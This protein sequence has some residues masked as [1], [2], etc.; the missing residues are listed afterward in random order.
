MAVINIDLANP[1]WMGKKLTIDDEELLKSLDELDDMIEKPEA[2]DEDKTGSKKLV[3]ENIEYFDEDTKSIQKFEDKIGHKLI[4]LGQGEKP[5]EG[6]ILYTGKRGG[7][8][9]HIPKKTNS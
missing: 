7:R 3:A 9:Y 4:H 2:P 1:N 5:P 6:A 8:Y